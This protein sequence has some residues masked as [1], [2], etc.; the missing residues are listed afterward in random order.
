M[1]G[2]IQLFENCQHEFHFCRREINNA[3]F[4][5]TLFCRHEITWV[6]K[7]VYKITKNN[8]CSQLLTNFIQAQSS[9]LSPLKKLGF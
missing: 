7:T 2:K 9:M 4:A 8:C 5:S 1:F 6:G 3:T